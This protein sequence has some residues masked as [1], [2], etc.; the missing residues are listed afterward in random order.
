MSEMNEAS[1]PVSW[2][3]RFAAF[4]ACC[5]FGLI[6]AGAL[7]TS[8]GAGLS[9]PDWPTSFGSFHFPRLVHGVQFEFTHRL[10][11]GTVGLLTVILAVW[12]SFSKSRRYVKWL[13]WIAV[14]T[15]VA[16]AILGGVGVLFD[17]PVAV[18]VAHA[19]LAEIFFLL[20]VSLALFTRTD[21][22]WDEPKVPDVSSPALRSLAVWT[23]AAIFLQVVLGAMFRYQ[24]FGIAPHI[25]GGVVVM[26]LVLWLLETVLNKF[27]GVAGLKAAA[28]LLAAVT[29][30]QF[31]LGLFAYSMKLNAEKATEPMPG[32]AVMTTTHVAIGALVTAAS[33]FVVYQ[34]FKYVAPRESS[35]GVRAASREMTA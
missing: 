25:L 8:N 14:L 23:C 6:V 29:A 9:V 20:T 17:L 27:S 21:W 3:H 19:S 10:I 16:Q 4:V 18:T 33:L 22:R 15:V 11:A 12:L 5:T 31:F 34:T 26:I 1:N 2:L 28:V 35:L 32:V 13:G 24:E 7:V 30:L